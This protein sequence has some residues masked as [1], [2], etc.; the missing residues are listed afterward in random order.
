MPTPLDRA[1]QSRVRH[2]WAL[3]ALLHCAPESLTKPPSQNTFLAFTGIVT[4]VAAWT[5]WGS[6]MFPAEKD[7]SGGTSPHHPTLPRTFP[8]RSHVY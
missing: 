7:P 2:T 3:S 5:I 4:A 6:D 1:L 8:Y